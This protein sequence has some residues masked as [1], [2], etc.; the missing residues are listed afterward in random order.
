MDIGNV[1]SRAWQII[2][3]HKVLWIF[4]ILA[5]CANSGGSTSNFRMNGDNGEVPP[6]MQPFVDQFQNMPEGMIIALVIGAILV[7]LILMVL[8][9]FL[10]TIGKIGLVR[11]TQQAE[12]G[13]TSLNFGELFNGSMPFFWRV[14]GL[15]LL[16]G[17]TIFLVVTILAV[18]AVIGAVLTIGVGLLCILPFLC[19][20][21]PVGW[22]ISLVVEQANIAIVI[23]NL[24]IM[25]GL[26]RGWEVVKANAGMMVVMSLILWLAINGIAGLILGLPIVLIV[27]P[28]VIGLA[29]N[30]NNGMGA[31]LLTA[32]VC[33]VLYLPVLI[34]AGGILTGY[35]ETAWTLTYMRLTGR[36]A[37]AAP[38]LEPLS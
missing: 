29:S 22:A 1:L 15:N 34:V 10:G 38:V 7:G 28:A 3:K 19:L 20:L 16:V 23:E 33:F 6:Q 11:G 37:A 8:A 17:L 9:I 14:F 24:Q 36:P 12:A 4:G 25:D 32:A 30:T 18:M 21:I 27:V 31:G 35:I 5:G 13:A 26:R 2:W